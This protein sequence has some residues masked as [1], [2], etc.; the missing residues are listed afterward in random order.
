[1]RVIHVIAKGL[2]N[3]MGGPAEVVP[4]LC[5]TLAKLGCDVTLVTLEGPFSE[6]TVQCSKNGVKLQPYPFVE[7]HGVGYSPKLSK[8]LF[9]LAKNVDILHNHGLWQYPNWA[10]TRAAC[11]YKKPLIITPHGS[12][13]PN[14]LQRNRCKKLVAWYCFDRRSVVNASCVHLFRQNEIQHTHHLGVTCPL[15]V[16]PNGVDLWEL[17][18][19]DLFGRRYPRS[20]GKK[21]LLFFGRVHPTK[22]IFDL[23][24]AWARTSKR[25]PEWHLVVAGRPEVEC[26]N[27]VEAKIKE[28]GLQSSATLVG[29][30]Y[31]QHRLEAYA[32]ADAFVLPSYTEGFST[33]I[34][35]AMAC[36]LPVVYT[37]PC[38]FPEAARRRAGFIGP[39]GIESLVKN[40]DCLMRMSNSERR[41]MGVNG[42]E[43]VEEKYTWP[44]IGKQ[45][46]KVYDWIVSGS[47][48]PSCIFDS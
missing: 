8:D 43:L 41:Q 7:L 45:W 42:R 29:P 24:E 11:R 33:S 26:V 20:C 28:Y 6:A 21:I 36:R 34:L 9:K 15:A 32:A 18:N 40:L 22:G 47:S 25:Y 1:M 5:S 48:K 13:G 27:K 10:A 14:H 16:I 46:L 44:K 4:R 30:Q 35:E 17:P 38:N 19:G 31:G 12:L 37:E 2:W 3:Y 39:A 23:L